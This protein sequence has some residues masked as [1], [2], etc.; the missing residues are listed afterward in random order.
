VTGAR[1]G[2]G[3]MGFTE[4]SARFGKGTRPTIHFAILAALLTLPVVLLLAF[5]ARALAAAD[6]TIGKEAPSRVEPNAQFD[7]VLT[8]SNEGA[9]PATGVEVSDELPAGV[10]LEDVEAPA[11]VTCADAAGTVTC[12]PFDLEAGGSETI[13]LT[14][15]APLNAGEIKN[16]ATVSSTDDP[17]SPVA[18]NEVTTTVAPNLVIN[19]LDDPDPVS[20]EALLLYTL[21]VQNQGEGFA[22]GVAVTD[23]LPLDKVDFVTVDSSDF[24]CK[25]TAGVVQCIGGTLG[26]GEIAKVEIVVEP[27]KAGTISNTGAVFVQGVSNALDTDTETT[28]VNGGGGN[29]GGGNGGGTPGGDDLPEGDQCSPVVERGTEN[30]IGVLSGTEPQGFIF[31]NVF[32]D[33]LP[34]R[35]VYATSSENGSLNITAEPRGGGEPI[36]DETIQ[37]KKRGV[38]EVDTEPGVDYEILI[39]PEDQGYAIQFE[40]GVGPEECTDPSDLDPP[41]GDPP[42]GPGGEDGTNGDSGDSGVNDPDDVI[43][44]TVSDESLP[45]TGGPSLPGLAVIALGLAVLGGATVVGGV[46]RR[47]R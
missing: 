34:L 3:D 39:Q 23:E 29:G 27:E 30:P 14:V 18:S 37:G 6:L 28:K 47:D 41:A 15:R 9:D 32:N 40:M 22:G 11:G 4:H 21:R 17:D 42:A 10:T 38:I 12:D 35:I 44:D 13:T 24:D 45:P 46:R 43:D 7:Y 25:F 19:K 8:V 16:R 33:V 2:W 1:K 26:P 20:T 5:P 31:T 36:L